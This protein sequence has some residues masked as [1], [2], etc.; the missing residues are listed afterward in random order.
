MSNSKSIATTVIL[1]YEKMS[2]EMRE[3]LHEDSP[4]EG[5]YLL[6]SSP[7]QLGLGLLMFPVKDET[8][9]LVKYIQYLHENVTNLFESVDQVTVAFDALSLSMAQ[10]K[11][12]AN[13][14][15][16]DLNDAVDELTAPCLSFDDWLQVMEEDKV[17]EGGKG[18][19]LSGEDWRQMHEE[20]IMMGIEED[21]L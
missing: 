13:A 20:M 6:V 8:D 7:S 12:L 3:H 1:P 16:D 21:E 11:Q 4:K 2:P 9:S 10:D 5:S 18:S 19:T 14:I 15:M 17:D